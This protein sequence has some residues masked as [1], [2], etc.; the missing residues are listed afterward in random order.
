MGLCYTTLKFDLLE[1]IGGGE[2]ENSVVYKAF[3][4][5]L[6]AYL[7]IKKIMKKYGIKDSNY[8]DESRILYEC[9]HSN[10][11]EIRYASEDE[12]A[13]YFS[14][15]ICKN[16][17]LNNIIEKKYLSV[18]EII[19]YSLE[20]LL[21]IH[22]I[23]TKE[24]IHFD[25]KPTN[26]LI[27]N[28]N[29]AIVTDFGLARYTDLLGFAKPNVTYYSHQPPEGFTYLDYTNKSDIY[30]AGVTMYRMCTCNKMFNLMF[31]DLKSKGKLKNAIENG[32]FPDRNF[33]L[34]Y[35]PVQL[36]KVINKAMSID[37]DKRYDTILDMINDI[38]KI[39]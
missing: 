23:H 33:Y 24:L 7:V 5:Q 13:L 10:I 1:R 9:K 34:P 32:K 26:I 4:P 27:D 14:M 3:D 8:F 39:E 19:K 11:M 36:I 18:K 31:N 2:G 28:N 38:S 35:I 17:S 6:N 29:K 21:G 12:E 16:G 37:V 20:F 30:Q 22:Y 15:P 25:I